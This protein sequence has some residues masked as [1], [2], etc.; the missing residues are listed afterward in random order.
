MTEPGSSGHHSQ[1]DDD[2]D[3]R[4]SFTTVATNAGGAIGRKLRPTLQAQ[5][6]GQQISEDE[7]RPWHFADLGS[8]GAALEHVPEASSTSI[9]PWDSVSGTGG[10]G[11]RVGLVQQAELRRKQDEEVH[12]SEKAAAAMAEQQLQLQRLRHADID[13]PADA[14]PLQMELGPRQ[15]ARSTA[16]MP[17]PTWRRSAST[18]PCCVS[19]RRLPVQAVRHEHPQ[20][21]LLRADA[22][23]QQ[24]LGGVQ[25]RQPYGPDRGGS[26]AEG[27]MM[28]G[29]RHAG[30]RLWLLE[31]WTPTGPVAIHR[32]S[33]APCGSSAPYN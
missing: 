9:G 29:A 17:E 24:P 4:D 5:L 8:L 33:G 30:R 21:R 28:S 22:E 7:E 18:D 25:Q 6:S 26:D 3:D 1:A 27:G 16:R 23:W 2:D 14:A 20:P 11:R 31:C 15:H 10:T 32:H 12:N 19:A 13:A